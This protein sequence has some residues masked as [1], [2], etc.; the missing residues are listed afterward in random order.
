MIFDE[1]GVA[2]ADVGDPAMTFRGAVGAVTVRRAAGQ[3]H[4]AA[5]QQAALAKRVARRS[6]SAV[7]PAVTIMIRHHDLPL[8]TPEGAPDDN[9]AKS[10][11]SPM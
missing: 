10:S 7:R 5:S 1:A 6:L 2:G 9:H 11:I 3:R 8:L 4:R